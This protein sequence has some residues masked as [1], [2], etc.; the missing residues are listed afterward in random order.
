MSFLIKLLFA[1]ENNVHR[2]NDKIY[3]QMQDFTIVFV[4][5]AWARIMACVYSIT[6]F[7]EL[8]KIERFIK[9]HYYDCKPMFHV[10]HG[11]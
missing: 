7:F 8:I 4:I 10:A 5:S 1:L 6:V 2:C 9:N 3:I 11:Y